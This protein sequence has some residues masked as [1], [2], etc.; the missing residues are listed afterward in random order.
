MVKPFEDAAFSLEVGKVSHAVETQYGY[1][2]I[3]V[4]DKKPERK[5]S[6]KEA[7]KDIEQYLIMQK[8]NKEKD[9]FI[10]HLKPKARVERFLAEQES[11]KSSP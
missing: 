3:K 4:V 7:E 8:V 10:A 5:L 2:L 1:H 11:T 6:L 9:S